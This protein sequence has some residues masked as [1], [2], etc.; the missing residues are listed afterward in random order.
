[1]IIFLGLLEVDFARFCHWSNCINCWVNSWLDAM[2]FGIV[3][4]QL[5]Y[6]HFSYLTYL[7]KHFK[8]RF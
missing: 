7:W 3:A 8:H 5:T 4:C 6:W 2:F 1:M